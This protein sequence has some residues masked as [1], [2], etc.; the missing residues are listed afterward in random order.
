MYNNNLL[1]ECNIVFVS[2]LDNI[3]YLYYSDLQILMCLF[4]GK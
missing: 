4:R 1:G 3:T 2:S